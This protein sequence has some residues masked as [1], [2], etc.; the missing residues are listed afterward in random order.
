MYKLID[1]CSQEVWI[2]YNIYDT[3]IF[4][5][6]LGRN[7]PPDK[8]ALALCVLSDSETLLQDIVPRLEK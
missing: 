7:F 1:Y 5:F 4:Y 8:K 2:L 3:N 6:N